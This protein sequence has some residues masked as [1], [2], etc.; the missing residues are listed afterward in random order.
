MS[1]VGRRQRTSAAGYARA[2]LDDFS[3]KLI[4]AQSQS[5]SLSLSLS[6]S[7]SAISAHL[8]I[9]SRALVG[10]DRHICLQHD[11]IDEIVIA[12]ACSTRNA[13]ATNI[14]S[15]IRLQ[16]RRRDLS[17]TRT[18]TA[19]DCSTGRSII[20]LRRAAFVGHLRAADD[21]CS[22]ATTLV[23]GHGARNERQPETRQLSRRLFCSTLSPPPL[24]SCSDR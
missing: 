16:P 17:L 20:P 5:Q 3:A 12:L 7:D 18:L 8:Y 22:P 4:S 6:S 21:L 24:F 9:S 19:T 13:G 11:D 1:V 15:N 2:D 14:E 10:A 23:V